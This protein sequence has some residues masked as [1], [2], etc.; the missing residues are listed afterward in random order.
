MT[1]LATLTERN[2]IG[3]DS[4]E[5]AIAYSAHLLY[6]AFASRN[7]YSK[8]FSIAPNPTTE[9]ITIRIEF[10]VNYQTFWQSNGNFIIGASNFSTSTIPYLG[11]YLPPSNGDF[12]AIPNNIDTLER[13][14]VYSVV[15]FRNYLLANYPT[16]ENNCTYGF[17]EKKRTITIKVVLPYDPLIYKDYLDLL[18]AIKN[19]KDI[20]GGGD[21][22]DNLPFGNDIQLSNDYQ[23]TN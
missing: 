2:Q 14:F 11:E 23:L 20:T 12:I 15:E 16:L 9:R 6:S 7:D 10:P 22:T 13:F 8:D 3:I 1:T 4:F 21:N 18:L 17:N 5:R 19:W